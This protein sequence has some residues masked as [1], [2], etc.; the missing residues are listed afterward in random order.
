MIK[1]LLMKRVLA[2]VFSV[3]VSSVI[4]MLVAERP[5]IRWGWDKLGP[6]VVDIAQDKLG[7]E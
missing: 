6:T 3:T 2:I 5:V 4:P 1:A 7:V